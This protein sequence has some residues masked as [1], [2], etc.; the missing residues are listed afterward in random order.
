[1][2]I[3]LWWA[4]FPLCAG[5]A[6]H[7]SPAFGCPE[8]RLDPLAEDQLGQCLRTSLR[9]RLGDL[10]P[11]LCLSVRWSETAPEDEPAEE[12]GAL[13]DPPCAQADAQMEVTSGA[14]QV[15][16]HGV[17]PTSSCG[18]LDLRLISVREADAV[19]R[20]AE[21]IYAWCAGRGPVQLRRSPWVDAVLATDLSRPAQRLDTAARVLAD[22]GLRFGGELSLRVELGAQLYGRYTVLAPGAH[23]LLGAGHTWSVVDLSV[24]GGPGARV[25]FAGPSTAQILPSARVLGTL[26]GWHRIG[27]EAWLEVGAA[28][29][30][31]QRYYP[32]SDPLVVQRGAVGGGLALL[33][34]LGE[35]PRRDTPGPARKIDRATPPV[36]RVVREVMP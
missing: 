35:G 22:R 1:V 29:G 16:A 15:D 7:G 8:L 19:H 25:S 36:S 21:V 33:L 32:D 23:L 31:E 27:V 3:S 4:M 6:F 13:H 2:S 14:W 11:Q 18:R 9:A 34:R 17:E 24:L 30:V 10:L 20:I 12:E 26:T 28:I 5:L